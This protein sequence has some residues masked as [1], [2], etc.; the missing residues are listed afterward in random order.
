MNKAKEHFS[1]AKMAPEFR[2]HIEASIP[3]Y[4]SL[5][6]NCVKQSGS[7]VRP[8]T[9]VYDVGCTTGHVLASV[10]RVNRKT[11]PVV[12]YL[13]IDL[14]PEF[15]P[16]WDEHKKHLNTYNTRDLSFEL[17]D[18]RGYGFKR[19]SLILSLFTVQFIP[20]ADKAA[21]LA[22]FHA[23]LVN[24]GALFIAEKTLAE[25]PRLQERLNSQYLDYKRAAGFTAE[26]I[27]DKDHALQRQMTTWTDPELRDALR[28]A[29]FRELTAF[30]RDLFFVGYL[31]VK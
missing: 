18:A 25:T 4:K 5:I 2:Q 26:Q 12:H 31:A 22:R 27:L 13:G 14:E 15:I 6:R 3:S 9:N 17:Q 1:F 10:R 16:Y 11:H 24:G 19:A 21:L 20:P 30:W 23:A 29:G 28:A 7:F 8:G